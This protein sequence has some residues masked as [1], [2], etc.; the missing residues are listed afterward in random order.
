MKI[1]KAYYINALTQIS[2]IFSS[3]LELE[4]GTIIISNHKK[5]LPNN[6]NLIEAMPHSGYK[7]GWMVKSSR[8]K[9]N[10][11]GNRKPATAQQ[12][13]GRFEILTYD[14]FEVYASSY[15]MSRKEVL[16]LH[17]LIMERYDFLEESKIYSLK[18]LSEIL[19]G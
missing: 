15:V 2:G 5:P 6:I 16:K 14:Q 3:K 7:N 19:E 17:K 9:F 12:M 8:S 1:I 4:D 10:Q 11:S 18:W 13:L